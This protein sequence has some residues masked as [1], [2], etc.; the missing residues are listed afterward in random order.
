M[1]AE[2][3][4]RAPVQGNGNIVWSLGGQAPVFYYSNAGGYVELDFALTLGTV[5][6]TILSGKN[7]SAFKFQ[8]GNYAASVNGGTLFTSSEAQSWI[9]PTSLL[10]GAGSY[11]GL[12]RVNGP[13]ARLAYYTARLPNA[14]LQALTAT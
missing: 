6:G 13:I 10:I 12:T 8:Q 7:K 3:Y 14:Q 4:R 1:V 2:Y 5:T 9:T 11:V